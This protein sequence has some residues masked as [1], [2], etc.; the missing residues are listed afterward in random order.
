MSVNGKVHSQN[1]LSKT[2]LLELNSGL[3]KIAIA[4]Q[5]N[6]K[7][8]N[9]D[10]EII[11]SNIFIVSFYLPSDDQYRLLHLRQANLSAAK[12]FAQNPIVN[13]ISQQG[14]SV[15]SKHFFPVSQSTDVILQSTTND[16]EIQQPIRLE[17]KKTS[18]RK[19]EKN[20]PKKDAEVMLL[21]WWQQANTQQRESFLETISQTKQVDSGNN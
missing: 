21:F 20:T 5:G 13:I 17:S 12:K 19:Q 1:L 11:K 18:N 2:S 16:I 6:F 3:N 9:G 10:F 15:K 7:N 4:Y 14:E 8:T